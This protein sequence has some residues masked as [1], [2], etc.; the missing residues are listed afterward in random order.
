M[1]ICPAQYDRVYKGKIVAVEKDKVFQEI[2]PGVLVEHQRDDIKTI[3]QTDVGKEFLISYDRS[4]VAQI[5]GI[6]SLARERGGIE[7]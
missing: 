7:R 3:G 4:G 2:E 5:K 1:Q 6:R